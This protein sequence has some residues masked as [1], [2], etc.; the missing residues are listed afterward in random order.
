[1]KLSRVYKIRNADGRFSTGG[2][3]PHWTKCGKVWVALNHVSAHLT[4]LRTN[5]NERRLHNPSVENPYEGCE[6]IAYEYQPSSV[7]SI[8]DLE[9]V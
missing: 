7:S 2:S 9:I 8:I 4:L 3:H 6:L 1:M 5:W